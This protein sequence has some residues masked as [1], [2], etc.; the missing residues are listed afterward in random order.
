MLVA[1]VWSYFS[2]VRLFVTLWTVDCQALLSMGFSRQECWGGLPC[3]PPGHLPDPGVKPAS[4]M[5]PALAGGF[6]TASATWE[7][8]ILVLCLVTQLCPTPC[9]SMDFSPPSFSVHEDSPGKNTGVGC[10]TLL[11]GIFPT[12]DQSQVSR[13]VGGFFTVWAPGKPKNTG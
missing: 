11:Q 5:S 13:I 7:A 8:H 4:L 9:D 2:R 10:H 6:F 3:P 12:R 1:C